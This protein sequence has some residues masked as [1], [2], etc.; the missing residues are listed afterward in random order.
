MKIRRVRLTNLNSLRGSHAVDFLAAPLAGAGLFAITGP[1]GAGKSTLLD[2][3]TLALYG[4]AAR[5]GSLPS[6]EDMLSRHCGECLAEV[7]F[8]VPAGIFRAEWQLRRARG[9]ADGNL[10]PAKRYVYDA[11]G[12]TL[13]QSVTEAD[14]VIEQLIGLNY[15]RFVRSALLAQGDFAQFLKAKADDRAA[16][17]ESLTGTA[18]YS[19]LSTLA[20]TEANRRDQDWRARESALQAIPLLPPE[21]RARLLAD[22]PVAEAALAEAKARLQAANER[23][24]QAAN[25]ATALAA[26]A[27]ARDQLAALAR[28]RQSAAADFA[29][30]ARH[31]L[32]QPFQE[33]LARLDAA[34]AAADTAR[35]ELGR[36]TREQAAAATAVAACRA[37]LR[38]WVAE[39]RSAAE[40]GRA[41]AGER[42]RL[43]AERQTRAAAWL[44]EH[45]AEAALPAALP[46]LSTRLTH[47]QNSH[48]QSTREWTQF[49]G[50]LAQIGRDPELLP[51]E[52]VPELSPADFTTLL[53]H[54]RALAGHRSALAEALRLRDAALLAAGEEQ[55]RQARLIASL[56][57]HRAGLQAGAPCPLCGATEHPFAAGT[58]AALPFKAQEAAVTEAKKQ[59]RQAEAEVAESARLERELAGV[60]E[61]LAQVRAEHERVVNEAAAKLAE[62]KLPPPAPGGEEALLTALK[63]TAN[64]YTLQA[65]V[66]DDARREHTTATEELARREAEVNGWRERQAGL[67]AEPAGSEGASEAGTTGAPPP[68]RWATF[69][70]ADADWQSVRQRLAAAAA[71]LANRQA[72]ALRAQD[73]LKAQ[74]IRLAEA[75]V[76]SEFASLEAVKTARLPAAE[77]TRGEAVE[78]RLREREQQAGAE[79]RAAGTAV[80]GWRQAGAPEGEAAAETK[81]QQAELQARHDQLLHDLATGKSQLAQDDRHRHTAAT[82]AAALAAERPRIAVWQQ[83]RALI[84]SHDGRTFR[85]YAQSVSLEVLLHYANRQLRR[86]NDRYQLRRREG[87][88]LEL[89]ITDLHQAGTRRPMASLSGGETFLAS[90]ALALGLSDIAGRKV[91]IESL[92]ID[93]GFGTLDADSLDLA[94]A[95]LETLRQDHKTVGVISHVELLKERIATQI[96]V[97]KQSG[98]MSVLRVVG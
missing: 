8:E 14:R 48:R 58:P 72:D 13:A 73:A 87:E 84:G 95:A 32:T 68:P 57:T 50:L 41:A 56:E 59:C 1:T 74:T 64:A 21:Q 81:R 25:L 46:E 92:F 28:E 67:D 7:E 91:R 27:R 82:Q 26:E 22:L 51:P 18:I 2:A 60:G 70:A 49:R 39:A 43:A 79:Q 35:T 38:L 94:I 98:G 42:I 77:A 10:Q 69:T 90:L 4:R 76:G 78:N 37:G 29:R 96:R 19:E 31:R 15:E 66:A 54:W 63:Q 3:I 61:R 85:R 17:L 97:E 34:Q 6:P 55:L 45:A 40:A 88:E 5:Y 30:L 47:R 9:K 89:E 33:H 23:L 86:L 80:A 75:L 65:K 12:A 20:H 71:T 44:A 53:A 11:Q 93:E 83:L 52:A 16:L 36:A 62:F 24:N